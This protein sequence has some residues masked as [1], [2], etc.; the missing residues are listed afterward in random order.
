MVIDVP[1]EIRH[2]PYVKYA[3]NGRDTVHLAYTEGHPRDFDNGVFHAA[4][5]D[6]AFFRS[7]GARIATLEEGLRDPAEGTRVFEGDADNVAWVVDLELDDDGSPFVGFSVQKGSAGRPSGEGGEDH[8]YHLARWTGSRWEDEEIAFA[9]ARLYPGEDD[10]TGGMALV[11]GNPDTL[12]LSTN[13][14]PATGAPL[15]SRTDG[16]RHWEL[17]RGTRAARTNEATPWRWTPVTR[18]STAD[19]LRPVVPRT[20][21]GEPVLLWLRG[22]YRSYTDY[23]L[24]IVGLL[25]P[26]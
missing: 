5:I 23:D 26:R 13:A 4:L 1:S 15:V 2:R 7:D 3:S 14:D 12:F 25:P 17:F 22:T 20:A 21:G 6:G 18:D 9:G 11:P 16:R 19:H 8:R 24:E 10:Y